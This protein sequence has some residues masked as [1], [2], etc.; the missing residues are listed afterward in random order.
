MARTAVKTRARH[1]PTTDPEQEYARITRNSSPIARLAPCH[2]KEQRPGPRTA[3]STPSRSPWGSALPRPPRRRPSATTSVP[4]TSGSTIGWARS[5]TTAG[6]TATRSLTRC[7]VTTARR[8]RCWSTCSIDATGHRP[9][10]TTRARSHTPWASPASTWSTSTTAIPARAGASWPSGWASSPVPLPSTRSS[11]GRSTP[12]AAGARRSSSTVRS[13]WTGRAP[14]PAGGARTTAPTVAEARARQHA[15]TT[16]PVAA[17]RIMATAETRASPATKA[18]TT[19]ATTRAR[20]V[21]GTGT[22]SRNPAADACASTK[23]GPARGPAFFVQGRA[24]AVGGDPAPDLR[25]QAFEQG[26]V[27]IGQRF[28]VGHAHVLVDFVDAGVH[29]ADL[30]ALRAQRRDEAR[31]GRAAAGTFFRRRAGEFRQH[32]ARRGAQPA[33]G[34]EERLAAAVP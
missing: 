6:I 3:D 15:A 21:A 14:A 32:L 5:T 2:T 20:A 12:I 13:T 7:T 4:V 1:P 8:V 17:L 9:T 29:R 10:C 22:A 24:V 34:R 26:L 19:R 28:Q 27:E 18:T 11:A 16:P 30:D 33:L 25:Q 31:V 23:A